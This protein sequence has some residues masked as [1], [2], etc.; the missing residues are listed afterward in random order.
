MSK[1]SAPLTFEPITTIVLSGRN[2]KELNLLGGLLTEAD[3]PME[4]FF[5]TNPEAYY[6]RKSVLTAICTHPVDPKSI[7]EILG[8]LTLWSPKCG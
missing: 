7:E 1:K 6:G 3:V 5:D 2:N 4:W 8:H